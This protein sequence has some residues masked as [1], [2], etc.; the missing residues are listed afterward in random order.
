MSLRSGACHPGTHVG[1][2]MVTKPDVSATS[3]IPDR[4]SRVEFTRSYV[5]AVL[6]V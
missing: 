5:A 4:A 1:D 6:S 3:K 2:V